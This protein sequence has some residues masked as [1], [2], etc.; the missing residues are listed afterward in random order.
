LKN[1]GAKERHEGLKQGLVRK[2]QP[3]LMNVPPAGIR[4]REASPFLP[5]VARRQTLVL[6]DQLL[7]R[8]S[9]KNNPCFRSGLQ[10]HMESLEVLKAQLV[11]I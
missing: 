6:K 2:L 11:G 9:T 3:F 1:P 8:G 10:L 5:P 7:G 4:R